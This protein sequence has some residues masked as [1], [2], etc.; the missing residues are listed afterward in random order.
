MEA[1]IHRLRTTIHLIRMIDDTL[2][3]FQP[4]CGISVPCLRGSSLLSSQLFSFLL[5]KQYPKT[6]G[7]RFTTAQNHKNATLPKVISSNIIC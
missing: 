5:A 2:A 7:K 3:Y 1:G 4:R 6:K